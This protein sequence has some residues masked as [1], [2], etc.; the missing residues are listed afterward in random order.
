MLG[1]VNEHGLLGLRLGGTAF[2]SGA[3]YP[4]LAESGQYARV[5]TK[6][7]SIHENALVFTYNQ[8]G[9]DHEY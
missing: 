6:V 1:L 3:L 7:F 2:G 8:R 4:F 5:K 9:Y